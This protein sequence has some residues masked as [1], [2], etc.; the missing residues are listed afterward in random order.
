MNYFRLRGGRTSPTDDVEL[1]EGVFVGLYHHEASE[2]GNS[3][4]YDVAEHKPPRSHPGKGEG[5][6]FLTMIDRIRAIYDDRNNPAP[7]YADD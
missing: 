1:F 5:I 4:F 7:V 2:R 3:L 6:D